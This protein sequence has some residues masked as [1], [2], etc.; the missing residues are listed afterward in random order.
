MPS[1]PS[2]KERDHDDCL[3]LKVAVLMEQQ[4]RACWKD[5]LEAGLNPENRVL[6]E[7]E[8]LWLKRCSRAGS[9]VAAVPSKQMGFLLG[10]NLASVCLNFLLS[11]AS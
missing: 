2:Q 8:Q 7:D 6:C 3:C 5:L 1:Q 4:G 11:E 10:E 9:S